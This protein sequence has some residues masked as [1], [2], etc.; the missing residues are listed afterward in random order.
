MF[1]FDSERFDDTSSRVFH[2]SW[3][4][5][6]R[7]DPPNRPVPSPSAENDAGR[8]PLSQTQSR[9]PHENSVDCGQLRGWRRSTIAY[10]ACSAENH[11]R[12]RTGLAEKNPT[13]I[14]AL[15]ALPALAIWTIL[16]RNSFEGLVMPLLPLP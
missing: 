2:S 9:A 11:A 1:P 16:K 6:R 10:I 7:L 5:K 13:L 14:I 4:T 3:Q 8:I 15:A 12:F